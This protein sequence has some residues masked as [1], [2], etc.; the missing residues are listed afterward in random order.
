MPR[1]TV[2]LDNGHEIKVEGANEAGWYEMP[3]GSGGHQVSAGLGM[4]KDILFEAVQKEGNNTRTLA[5]FNGRKV[6]GYV[7]DPH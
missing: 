6:V 2:V 5:R 3:L 7:F 1:V 4:D